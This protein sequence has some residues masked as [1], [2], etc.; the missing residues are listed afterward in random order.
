[1]VAISVWEGVMVSDACD[2][3]QGAWPAGRVQALGPFLSVPAADRPGETDLGVWNVFAN[4][5][6]SR[7]QAALGESV[8]GERGPQQGA[9]EMIELLGR[10]LAV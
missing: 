9:A 7:P 10:L 3:I 4:P 5:A 2:R 1:M 8:Q 6:L